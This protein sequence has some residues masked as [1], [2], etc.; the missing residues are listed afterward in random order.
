LDDLA[1]RGL[2]WVGAGPEAAVS[3]DRDPPG[4]FEDLSQG[5]D[6]VGRMLG[7]W[8]KYEARK[9]AIRET[10][11]QPPELPPALRPARPTAGRP[12]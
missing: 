1:D 2:P 6:E 11:D 3:D 9:E 10:A 7:G 12:P 8:R 4:G 5:V